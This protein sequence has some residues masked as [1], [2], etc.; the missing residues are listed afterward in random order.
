MYIK[1]FPIPSYSHSFYYIHYI[2]RIFE[3]FEFDK[4]SLSHR[5]A[6]AAFCSS[7][8]FLYYY[9]RTHYDYDDRYKTC[10]LW[11]FSVYWGWEKETFFS[12]ISSTI[13][14]IFM[15]STYFHHCA[16][17]CLFSC[18]CCYYHIYNIQSVYEWLNDYFHLLT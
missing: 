18:W 3:W 11:H 2:S 17:F 1:F 14:I 6:I 13:S 12:F 4:V 8:S 7:L 16:D 15:C 5:H 9:P 10:L